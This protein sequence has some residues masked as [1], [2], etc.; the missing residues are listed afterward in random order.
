MTLDYVLTCDSPPCMTKVGY[1]GQ[2][3]APPHLVTKCTLL[4]PNCQVSSVRVKFV[5]TL[6]DSPQPGLIPGIHLPTTLKNS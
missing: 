4:V 1:L 3:I 2:H 6:A 5:P